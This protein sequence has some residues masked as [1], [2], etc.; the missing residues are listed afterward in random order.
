[1]SSLPYYK[2]Y[3]RDF[4]EGTAKMPLLLKGAYSLILDL[5]YIHRGGL[6]ND[7]RYI[8]GQLG[9]SVRQ[10]NSLRNQLEVLGK[11]HIE[12]EVISNFRADKEEI[13]LRKFQDKQSE[14]ARGSNKNKGL[15]KVWLNQSESE[16]EPK[17]YKRFENIETATKRIA[18]EIRQRRS[19]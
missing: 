11:I 16:S 19:G 1:M 6:P 10:W 7:S 13:I 3:P 8:A 18:D 5:I 15:Q 14:N 12:N 2:K 17:G 4:L 9:C